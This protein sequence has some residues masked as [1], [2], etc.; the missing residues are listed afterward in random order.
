MTGGVVSEVEDE[1]GISGD[2]LGSEVE[3]ESGMTGDELGSEEVG[4]APQAPGVE[5]E[6]PLSS[7][8]RQNG[9]PEGL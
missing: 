5:V 3:D 8:E 7:T 9:F 4:D 1:S 2:E 6:M